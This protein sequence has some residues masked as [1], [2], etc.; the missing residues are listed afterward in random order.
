M[1]LSSKCVVCD[2]TKSNFIKLQEGT[3]LLSI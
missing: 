2:S 1:W 3:G